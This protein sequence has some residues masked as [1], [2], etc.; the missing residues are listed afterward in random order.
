MPLTLQ[1]FASGDT[2]YI[3]KHNGN[4][5]ATERAVADVERQLTGAVGAAISVGAA[6]GALL[7]TTTAVIGATS[8]KCTGS[9]STLTIQ[10]G[11]L[12]RP[13]LGLVLA[14]MTSRTLSFS[15]VAAGT[16]Y[17]VPDSAGAPT[18]STSGL[19]AAYEIVWGGSGFTSITRVAQIIWGAADQIAAQS[20]TA[21][22][23]SYET[24]DARLEAAEAAALGGARITSLAYAATL[25][26]SFA[27]ADI[28]R[29]T[30]AGNATITP[31]GAKDGQRMILELKQDTTGGRTVTWG[32]NVRFGTDLP[33]ITLSTAGGAL[34][35]VGLIYNAAA[36]K[37]D[38]V[39]L[40][41]GY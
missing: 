9:G 20:S 19:G 27:A 26:P 13:D 22:G 31:S 25:A 34:D 35:R 11:Y 8:Y 32:T 5:D 10:P 6:L 2:N 24:L 18:R 37:C 36:A 41:R 21:L 33:A 30:L 39:A 16:Y 29:V 7:G 4:A 17:M 1:R 12:W 23:A 14:L 28:V 15:G 3:S 38:V 40:Q